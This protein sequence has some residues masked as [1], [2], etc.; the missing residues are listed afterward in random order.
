MFKKGYESVICFWILF[1]C[2]HRSNH[3]VTM[4]SRLDQGYSRSP[5]SPPGWFCPRILNLLK[6]S[7]KRQKIFCL[8][9]SQLIR[10]PPSSRL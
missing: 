4:R 6:T 8:T 9:R 10:Y 7:G 2:M 3:A 1:Y 5:P